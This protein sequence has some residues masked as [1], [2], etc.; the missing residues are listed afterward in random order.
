MNPRTIWNVL[1]AY[2]SHLKA[3]ENPLKAN[4]VYT[5]TKSAIIRHLIPGWD[6]SL[7]PKSSSQ[8]TKIE[9][10]RSQEFLEGTSVSK[11]NEAIDV[12]EKVFERYDVSP[13]SRNVYKSRLENFINWVKE[14]GWLDSSSGRET[15]RRTPKR[16]RH[17]SC[18]KRLTNRPTNLPKY[19]LKTHSCWGT[20]KLEKLTEEVDDLYHLFVDERYAG[21]LFEPKK[22]TTVDAYVRQLYEIFGWLV[23]YENIQPE[24]LSFDLLIPTSLEALNN[25][26]KLITFTEAQKKSINKK[27]SSEE[28]IAQYIDTLT[29]RL[30]DFLEKER[31]CQSANT[32]SN[33]LKALHALVRYQ[34]LDEAEDARYRN[35]P[36]MLAINKHLNNCSKAASIQPSTVS[37]EEKWLELD[38][39]HKQIVNPL[40]LDC[41]FRGFYRNL[42]RIN[43]IAGSFMRF[44]CWGLMTFKPPRRQQEF[45]NLKITLCCQ[46]DDKPKSLAPNQFIHPLPQNRNADKYHGYLYKD[47]DGN[48]YQHMTPESYKTG[49][50]YKLQN[51]QIPNPKLPDGKYFYDYLEAYLYGYW[52]DRKGN[53]VSLGKT[54]EA[55]DAGHNLYALRMVLNPKN[56]HNFVFF[57]LK[58]GKPFKENNFGDFFRKTA[59]SLSGKQLTPHLIRDIYASW[60]LD[61]EYTEDVI[62]SLAYAMGHS[63]EELRKSYDKRKSHRKHEP[64]QKKLDETLNQLFGFSVEVAMNDDIPEGVDPALW[65]ILTSEQKSMY[66]K[67]KGT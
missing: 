58:Q 18:Y 5:Q 24:Q 14:Q 40:R 37:L 3:T 38:E 16:H 44:A 52:R 8:L 46:I 6:K 65:L 55:P 13:S 7:M 64:I 31:F 22:P 47:Q 20:Q 39:V 27:K 19:S 60:F 12:Q 41:E 28:K 66:R 35:I 54:V 59:H 32:L 1:L 63:P 29:C 36:A 67:L 26:L 10:A 25:N 4:Q 61:R 56:N 15:S 49:K 45:R 50:T 42:R 33:F 53:W 48:W 30:L 2:K 43:A 11:L 57:G 62:R 51:L 21:R 23:N 17:G 9:A 34:Y